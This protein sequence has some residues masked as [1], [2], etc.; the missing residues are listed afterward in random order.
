M[1]MTSRDD[2]LL[3]L[4]LLRQ[5]LRS[6]LPLPEALRMMGSETGLAGLHVEAMARRI[7][8]G[9]S[10]S[11]AMRERAHVFPSPVPELVAAGE[12]AG[13]PAETL[14]RAI[15]L[16]STRERTLRHVRAALVYPGLVL[17]LVVVLVAANSVFD[18][19]GSLEVRAGTGSLVDDHAW[20]LVLVHALSHHPLARAVL[21]ALTFA[22]ALA[23]V[24]IVAGG[25]RSA[26]RDRL[27]LNA[28]VV[29][30][31]HRL[32]AA[33]GFASALGEL[34]ESG[35]PVDRA[36]EQ[37]LPACGNL[38]CARE[39]KRRLA[40]V[41]D[42]GGLTAHLALPGVFPASL[43]WRL[44]S[45]EERGTVPRALLDAAEAYA[46]EL[47]IASTRLARVVEPL[48]MLAVGVAAVIAAWIWFLPYQRA[49]TGL[50]GAW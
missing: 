31:L 44:A 49:L 24:V 7:E 41:R 28:P 37:A 39:L 50:G 26:T 13:R 43:T 23:A 12:A 15:A 30:R 5:V 40:G 29:G 9:G 20:Y 1:A 47:E 10:L 11:E 2:V 19:I 3:F 48:A 35:V 38:W 6:R 32:S 14:D 45:G 42:G 34:L 27:L 16:V 46:M 18:P 36:I 33:T 17:A 25:G 8:E 4:T 22:L 21:L